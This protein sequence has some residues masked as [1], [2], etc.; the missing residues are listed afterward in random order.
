MKSKRNHLPYE[1][2]SK[3]QK[4]ASFRKVTKAEGGKVSD[5]G[6]AEAV[7]GTGK[8]KHRGTEDTEVHREKII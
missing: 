3:R 1:T 7:E 5:P 4:A 8:D 2:V 6:G